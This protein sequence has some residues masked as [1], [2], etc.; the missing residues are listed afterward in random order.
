MPGPNGQVG[1]VRIDTRGSDGNVAFQIR[2]PECRDAQVVD[3]ACLEAGIDEVMQL[4]TGNYHLVVQRTRDEGAAYQVAIAARDPGGVC[5]TEDPNGAPCADPDDD[6]GGGGPGG[7]PPPADHRGRESCGDVFD[8]G[9]GGVFEGDVQGAGDDERSNCFEGG[10]G[11]H[12]ALFDVPRNPQNLHAEVKFIP[13]PGT[14]PE[15]QFSV[16]QFECDSE[17]DLMCMIGHERQD[18][19]LEP[20]RYFLHVRVPPHINGPA[21]YSMT[22]AIRNPEN[23]QC[24][25]PDGDGDR[26]NLCDGDCDDRNPAVAPGLEEICNGIDDDCSGWADDPQGD[27]DT[28]LLGV[29]GVGKPRC[30]GGGDPVCEQV[31]FPENEVCFDGMDNDCDGGEDEAA[32]EELAPGETCGLAIDASAG[33]IFEG[34]LAQFRPDTAP[35]CGNGRQVNDMVLRIDVPDRGQ[36]D[37]QVRFFT[38]GTS[39]GVDWILRDGD[40]RRAGE[41]ACAGFDT[42][43]T[44][45][46][47]PG[48]WWLIAQWRDRN[49]PGRYRISVGV[50]D[51]FDGSC[52]TRDADGDGWTTCDGDCDDASNDVAPGAYDS[53]DGVD[54][55]CDYMIDNPRGEC[56]VP[57]AAGRCSAGHPYCDGGWEGCASRLPAL[58]EDVCGDDVDNDCDGTVDEPDQCVDPIVG[59]S[60]A[61]PILLQAGRRHFGDLQGMFP[62]ILP[63]CHEI[64]ERD[65]VLAFD[66]PNGA[67]GQ[68][69]WVRISSQVTHGEVVFELRRGCEDDFSWICQWGGGDW[70]GPLPPG[71]WHL[72]ANDFGDSPNGQAS[73]FE[74]EVEF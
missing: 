47:Q 21:R 62:D 38:H 46:L 49:Q 34:E 45:W 70:D 58:P 11:D 18:N 32:C 39:P 64:P 48:T 7:D 68:E 33:G 10:G 24:L 50:T 2:G 61:V 30:A 71:R 37:T 40:C 6:G 53:C 16:R 13:G 56:V 28:G 51:P 8:L 5:R 59:E 42:D 1:Q 52:M 27:C 31:E 26:V 73:R 12:V 44:H 3:G 55:D 65:Q 19:W 67:N 4:P 72:I 63:T 22:V 74:V 36:P 14:H 60:C 41:W 57:G 15:V 23:G 69:A 20:G 29:C 9:F 54:N 17:W 43:Q 35:G 66:V 25:I